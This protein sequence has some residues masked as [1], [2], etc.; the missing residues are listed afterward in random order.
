MKC[1]KWSFGY[2]VLC[3]VC[4]LAAMAVSAK[5]TH[6]ETDDVSF[7]HL[8]ITYCYLHWEATQR[9]YYLG[10]GTALNAYI[11]EKIGQNELHDKPFAFEIDCSGMSPM[12]DV[13][14]T[15][16]EERYNVTLDAYIT[17]TE[18]VQVI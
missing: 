7:S 2:K 8:S 11:V 12:L 6:R 1:R 5:A 16:D 3:S 9:L 15:E 18:L 10:L 13:Q 4:L 14:L 17:L